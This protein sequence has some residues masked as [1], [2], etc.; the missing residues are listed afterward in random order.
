MKDTVKRMKGRAAD[1]EKVVAK[2]ASDN[3]ACHPK[4]TKNC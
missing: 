1:W 3:K 4:Y 2:D